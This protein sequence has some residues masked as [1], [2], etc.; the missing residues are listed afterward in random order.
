MTFSIQER[1][2]GGM[3]GADETK[4]YHPDVIY[5]MTFP[6]FLYYSASPHMF[7]HYT[8]NFRVMESLAQVRRITVISIERY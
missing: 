4:P 1:E 8:T 3:L 5:E 6:K 2:K 7:L